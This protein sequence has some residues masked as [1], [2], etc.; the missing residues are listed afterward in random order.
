MAWNGRGWGGNRPYG[1]GNN[2]GG[3][4]GMGMGMGMN[5]GGGYPGNMMG[6]GPRMG[7]GY[8]MGGPPMMSPAA[9]AMGSKPA[10]KKSLTLQEVQNWLDK[11]QPFILQT[12]MK[13][14]TNLLINKHKV[15]TEDLSDWYK[16][17]EVPVKSGTLI[18]GGVQ[19]ESSSKALKRDLTPSTGWSKSDMRHPHKVTHSMKPLPELEIIP[20][21]SIENKEADID[22]DKRKMLINNVNM[23][24]VELS[25]ICHRFKIKPSELD[26]ENVEQ[27]PKDAQPKLKLAITCVSNAERTLGDFLDFLKNEKYKE[28]NDDQISKREA[29]LKSMIGETPQGK[30]HAS[31]VREEDIEL[32]DAQFDKD[33]NVVVGGGA[34]GFAGM[35]DDDRT[36]DEKDGMDNN[37]DKAEEPATKKKKDVVFHK[38]SN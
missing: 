26:K 24:Q 19:A 30:P 20:P 28:W 15:D 25:K 27:Y 37:A 38:A 10:V 12:V 23:M 36:Q 17:E 9:A 8:N 11:Q 29:L 32:V 1:H 18:E 22:R 5:M 21:F 14:C 16:D 33:G 31:A 4:G 2:F 13:H 35:P 6:G 3:Q 7:G 34:S